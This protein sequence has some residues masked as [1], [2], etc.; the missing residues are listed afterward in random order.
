MRTRKPC[1]LTK[2]PLSKVFFFFLRL[3]IPPFVPA[4]SVLEGLESEDLLESSK[5]VKNEIADTK[6]KEPQ[7]DSKPHFSHR[8]SNHIPCILQHCLSVLIPE[9]VGQQEGGKSA[10][11]RPA[12][13]VSYSAS[14]GGQ[15]R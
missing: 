3:N 12:Q 10:E 9:D 4:R 15:P 11:G 7:K 6:V 2:G 1:T 8:H 13:A 5:P 14:R